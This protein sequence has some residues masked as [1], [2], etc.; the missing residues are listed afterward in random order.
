MSIS[1]MMAIYLLPGPPASSDCQLAVWPKS[2]PQRLLYRMAFG[3]GL[4]YTAIP[5]F[6][7]PYLV[8]NQRVDS[9]LV[10]GT[11]V[12]MIFMEA[13]SITVLACVL[14]SH[15]LVRLQQYSAMRFPRR[16]KRLMR[17]F[18]PQHWWSL[19]V[20][21]PS[22]SH[23]AHYR[24]VSLVRCSWLDSYLVSLGSLALTTY[25]FKRT[26]YKFDEGGAGGK[27]AASFKS[28]GLT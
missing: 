13:G 6:L 19:G 12:E 27:V 15:H 1:L 9:K 7:Q 24:W 16:R 17:D 4:L 5:M 8:W 3:I 28:S 11:H 23:G 2:I 22:M 14:F 21:I 25:D 26:D 18:P 10:L 20:L